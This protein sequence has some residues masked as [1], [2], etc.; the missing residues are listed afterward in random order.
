MSNSNGAASAYETELNEWI[1]DEKAAI[2]LIHV[3]GE[4]WFDK[5]IELVIFRNQLVDRSASEILQLHNYA[6]NMVG[7]PIT[8]QDTLLLANEII[9]TEIAPARIDVGRLATEWIN[10]KAGYESVK[11]FISDKLNAFLG[12]D[13]RVLK[14]K[15]I[16]LYGFGRIGRIAAREL[17]IQA[18]KGEQLRLR[19]IVTRSNSDEDISKRAALLRTD[20]VHGPFPGTI[21]EDFENKKIIS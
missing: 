15:D 21:I 3:L 12:K 2:E 14:P 16:V 5:S 1:R 10:E 17:I 8:I 6:L 7:K 9:Q 4:L 11:E 20:S 19:A 13:K 18:G